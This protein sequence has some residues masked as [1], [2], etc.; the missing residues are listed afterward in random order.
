MGSDSARPWAPFSGNP[1]HAPEVPRPCVR[2]P[3]IVGLREMAY[4]HEPLIILYSFARPVPRPFVN[5]LELAA[6]KGGLLSTPTWMEDTT[7]VHS[8][9]FYRRHRQV[10]WPCDLITPVQQI[11]CSKL[12]IYAHTLLAV[13]C[14]ED[15]TV[16][17]CRGSSGH[18]SDDARA[19]T[20]CLERLSETAWSAND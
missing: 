4:R 8:A 11:A 9:P 10:T 16:C 13:C 3:E 7:H 14:M 12:H 5:R 20:H 17:T 19:I 6:T 1:V 18:W 2:L 15:P